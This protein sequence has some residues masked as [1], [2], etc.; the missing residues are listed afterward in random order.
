MVD[1][2]PCEILPTVYFGT[3]VGPAKHIWAEIGPITGTD[4]S[5]GGASS[6]V[7]TRWTAH[8][9]PSS[10]RLPSWKLQQREARNRPAPKANAIADQSARHPSSISAASCD[11]VSQSGASPLS[12]LTRPPASAFCSSRTRVRRPRRPLATPGRACRK[13]KQN[14]NSARRSDGGATHNR[15]HNF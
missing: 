7:Q 4:I 10:T 11:S 8:L 2:S 6:K 15:D 12:N 1:W 13:K 9:G 5:L 14:Q 3:I